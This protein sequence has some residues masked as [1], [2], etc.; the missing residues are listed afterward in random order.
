MKKK[1]NFQEMRVTLRRSWEKRIMRVFANGIVS[2]KCSDNRT[3]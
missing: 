3:I 2:V 1:E